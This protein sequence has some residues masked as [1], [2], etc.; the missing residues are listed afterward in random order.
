MRTAK[1]REAILKEAIV[2]AND[3]PTRKGNC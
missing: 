1:Q 3:W 2:K